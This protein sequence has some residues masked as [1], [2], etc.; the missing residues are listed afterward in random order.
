MSLFVEKDVNKDWK[1]CLKNEGILIHK[2]LKFLTKKEN[3][4][5]F[6]C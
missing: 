2:K 1:I 4:C 3:V 6:L 5:I